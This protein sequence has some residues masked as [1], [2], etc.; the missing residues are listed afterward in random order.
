MAHSFE[1]A[2]AMILESDDHPASVSQRHYWTLSDG[3]LLK[4]FEPPGICRAGTIRPWMVLLSGPKIAS[5]GQALTIDGYIPAGGSAN[6]ITVEP[7][8]RSRS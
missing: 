6:G 2:R 7:G 8:V 5:S 3:S 4:T 1:A